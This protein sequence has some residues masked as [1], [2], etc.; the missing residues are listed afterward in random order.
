[1]HINKIQL[2]SF[3]LEQHYD[4]FEIDEKLV[5][6]STELLCERICKNKQE[7]SETTYK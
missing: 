5:F 2:I 1:M 7:C 3:E 4:V 6:F